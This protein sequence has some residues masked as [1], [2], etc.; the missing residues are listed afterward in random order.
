[1]WA[2]ESLAKIIEVRSNEVLDQNLISSF[3]TI[4]KTLFHIA[5]AQHIWLL[6]LRG[7]SPADWPSNSLSNDQAITALR[8]T[9]SSLEE[10]LSFQSDT[11]F[12]SVCTYT[13]LDQKVYR[14]SNGN[15]IMHCMNHS[16][17]HRGQLITLLRQTGLE[18]KIPSTDL[19]TYLREKH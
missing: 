3:P 13:S 6:R 8:N 7:M 10:F 17:F 5:D 4:R 15:I 11:F 18:G 9:S 12:E 19:I 2:N 16:T 1:V 14:E